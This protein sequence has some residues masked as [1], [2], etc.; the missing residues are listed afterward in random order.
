MGGLQC[1][2]PPQLSILR[3]HQ[4]VAARLGVQRHRKGLGPGGGGGWGG[5][6]GDWGGGGGGEHPTVSESIVTVGSVE[7]GGSARR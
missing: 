4:F 5:G 6:V 1:R 7:G 2:R 3:W